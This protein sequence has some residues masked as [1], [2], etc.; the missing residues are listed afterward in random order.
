MRKELELQYEK[1]LIFEI[2]CTVKGVGTTTA[3][4]VAE[5]F[6]SLQSFLS[7]G[8]D[9]LRNIRNAKGSSILSDEKIDVMLSVKSEIVRG[10][11]VSETWIF[12]LAKSFVRNQIKTLSGMEFG[13][14]DINPFL[15]KALDLNTP[16]DIIRFKKQYDYSADNYTPGY[17]GHIIHYYS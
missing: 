13:D 3:G 10:K 4:A 14:L 6:G 17:L 7:S 16:K 1:D 9:A 2:C 5:Y 8:K 15:A 12:F 11:S